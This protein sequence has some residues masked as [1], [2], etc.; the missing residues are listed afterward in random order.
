MLFTRD[1]ILGTIDASSQEEVFEKLADRAM[2]LGIAREC[3]GQ[4]LRFNG[5]AVPHCITASPADRP[6]LLALTLDDPVGIDGEQISLIA[7]V[8]VSK[9]QEDKSSIF[10]YL[11]SMLGNGASPRLCLGYQELLGILEGHPH[12]IKPRG[13]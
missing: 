6:R 7:V 12:G 1:N 13:N 5:V 10:S 9:L 11:Y 4:C 3:Q 8:L 2:C